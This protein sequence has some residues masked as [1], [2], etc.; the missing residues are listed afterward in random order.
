[1]I[2]TASVL[3]NDTLA[4]R[5]MESDMSQASKDSALDFI[6]GTNSTLS[7]GEQTPDEKYGDYK[8]VQGDFDN[9]SSFVIDSDANS[10]WQTGEKD[11]V[12]KIANDLNMNYFETQTSG[13]PERIQKLYG[14][15]DNAMRAARTWTG[16]NT[17][18]SVL[19]SLILSTVK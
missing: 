12:K 4:V 15:W 6:L 19:K 11:S 1:M 2:L 3:Q 17:Q 8:T 5:I 18:N 16:P 7:V 9:F 14:S 13:I 10:Y